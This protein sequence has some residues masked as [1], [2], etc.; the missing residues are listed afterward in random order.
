MRKLALI[1]IVLFLSTASTSL[2]QDAVPGEILSR[3]IFIEAGNEA[4]TAFAVDYKGKLYLVTARHVIA[5]IPTSNATIQIWQDER[6]KDYKT[7]KTLFPASSN[8]DIAAFET[9]EKVPAPYQIQ[10][11]ADSGGATM[12][13]QV[14]FLG[15]PFGISSHFANGKRA[16][17]MK[18]G[19]LSAIDA[20]DP[21]AIVIYLDGFNN[22]GF[23]GGPVVF[24]DFS[25]RTYK[26]LAVVQGYRED[27]AKVLVNGQH[28]DTPLLVNTGIVTAYS[29]TH[30][31]KAIEESQKP[32]S[33]AK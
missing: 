31:M 17:F 16:P 5:G 26:I 28:V 2:A 9:D 1:A 19:T 30:I 4:G 7:V 32:P 29:I 13:Q 8:V 15:Y 12:G 21:D 24:W 6:W 11:L 25:S 23:S 33:P 3:T 27:S 18:R 14:W 22:P 20:T 10:P